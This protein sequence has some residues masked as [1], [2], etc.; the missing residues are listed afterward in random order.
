V[1]ELLGP[2]ASTSAT[3]ADDLVLVMA[4]FL[5]LALVIT[6]GLVITLAVLLFSL[7]FLHIFIVILVWELLL[8][9]LITPRL[10]CMYK[11]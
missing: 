10:K 2:E 7:P 5:I 11:L 6:L 1:N 3:M 9:L 4:P 8:L